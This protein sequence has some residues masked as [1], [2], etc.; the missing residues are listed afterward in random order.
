MNY[1]TISSFQ[2]SSYIISFIKIIS[3]YG[4]YF[5]GDIIGKEVLLLTLCLSQTCINLEEEKEGI[6]MLK[7]QN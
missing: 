1:K 5:E 6:E 2:W 3:H 4:K 7:S